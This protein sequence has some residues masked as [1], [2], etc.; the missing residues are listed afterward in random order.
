[1]IYGHF[2]EHLGRCIHGGIWGEML[3]ARRFAGFDDDHNGLADPWRKEA[4]RAPH[5]L[6][7]PPEATGGGWLAMRCL[8]DTGEYHEIAHPGLRVRQGE[9]Y[10]VEAEVRRESNA[11]AW[12][13][14]GIR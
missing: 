9:M 10:S 11:C 3:R 4:G 5:L 12:R 14:A 8:R 1:M 7:D 2:I 6:V 13:L